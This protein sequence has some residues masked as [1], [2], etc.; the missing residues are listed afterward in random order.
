MREKHAKPYCDHRQ[1][2]TAMS[3]IQH[4][5]PHLGHVE[6]EGLARFPLRPERVFG[7]HQITERENPTL[8][9]SLKL[10]STAFL[11]LSL[12]SLAQLDSFVLPQKMVMSHLT[13]HCYVSDRKQRDRRNMMQ[14]NNRAGYGHTADEN[15]NV[16]FFFSLLPANQNW[17]YSMAMEKSSHKDQ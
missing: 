10:L 11:K 2:Q 3:A 6:E 16:T 8:C 12:C 15:R 13:L 17:V 5:H 14:G 9:S 1:V 4:N 7:Q